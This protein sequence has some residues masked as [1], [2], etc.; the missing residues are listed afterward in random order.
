[1]FVQTENRTADPKAVALS[2][3]FLN[4][5]CVC[6]FSLA[7]ELGNC[8][9]VSLRGVSVTTTL[10]AL[11]TASAA[12]IRSGTPIDRTVLDSCPMRTELVD[13]T[14]THATHNNHL[15]PKHPGAS[16][17]ETAAHNNVTS[18]VVFPSCVLTLCSCSGT[19][20]Q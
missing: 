14:C 1:M 10:H 3:A 16:M 19:R 12:T 7:V 6:V 11:S 20:H 17:L 18:P 13:N 9:T 4:R 5:V 2:R 8:C 15:P